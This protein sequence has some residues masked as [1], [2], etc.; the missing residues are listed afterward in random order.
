MRLFVRTRWGI[1]VLACAACSMLM[2]VACSH[3]ET[4]VKSYQLQGQVISINA[5]AKIIIISH[6]E[7]PNL[8]PAMTMSY[9]V[10]D[11]KDLDGIAPGD[12]IKANLVLHDGLGHLENL[13]KI[14]PPPSDKLVDP[15]GPPR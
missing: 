12:T 5:P 2:F 8:M 11:A 14:T 3:K 7:I 10:E 9:S 13:Q 4:D 1:A 6:G 15:Q